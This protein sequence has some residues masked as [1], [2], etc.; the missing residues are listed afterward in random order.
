M[1]GVVKFTQV[2]ASECKKIKG[3]RIEFLYMHISNT[4]SCFFLSALCNGTDM[5][6]L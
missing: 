6:Y 3:I 4:I 5:L 2:S 1:N